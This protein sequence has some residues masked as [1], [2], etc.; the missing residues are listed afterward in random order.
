M[1]P[2]ATLFGDGAHW[3]DINQGYAGTCYILASMGAVAEFPEL[4]ENVFVNQEKNDAGIYKLRFYIRGKP[5][6]VTIDDEMLVYDDVLNFAMVDPEATTTSLW[7]PLVEKA[8]AKMKGNYATANGGFV[9]NGLR[10]LVGC[11]IS[12]YLTEENTDA[13]VVWTAMKEADGLDYILGAGTFGSD[14]EVNECNVVAGHAYSVIAVF[15]LKT[16][17]TVDHKMYMVRNPWGT[18][19]YDQNWRHDDAR[20]TEDYISQVPH[21][22]NPT[23]SHLDGIFFLEDVDFLRCLDDFQIAYMR[24][25]EGYSKDWYDVEGDPSGIWGSTD[26]F[27]T[28]PAQSGDLYLEVETYYQG[29]VHPKCLGWFQLPPYLTLTISKN[30]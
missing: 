5:W 11:P 7:A 16:G 8:F 25:E 21:G 29:I 17:E 22:I 3:T 28:V 18:T 1:Y 6:V 23:E 24:D 20:W 30:D 12:D 26:F 9:P 15:E 10:S 14:D 2:D 27:V 4:I 13:H 19:E